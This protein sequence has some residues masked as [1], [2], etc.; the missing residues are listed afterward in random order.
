MNKFE[1]GSR[2]KVVDGSYYEIDDGSSGQ[3]SD[4]TGATGTL[5]GV[6]LGLHM[7]EMDNNDGIRLAFDREELEVIQ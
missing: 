1:I 3:L 5:L 6:T 2:V 4:V 7:V